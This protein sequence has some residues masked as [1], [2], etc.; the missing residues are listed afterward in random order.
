MCAMILGVS[1]RNA[2]GKGEVMAYLAERGFEG[3]SLSDVLRDELRRQGLAE[4]R[5]R[6]IALG[7]K[8]R[9][10]EGEAVLA[11]RTLEGCLPGRDYAIDS[12]RHPAEVEALAAGPQA[13]HLLWIEAGAEVR[14]ARLRQR[15]R[16][17]DP[18]TFDEFREL[19][20]RELQSAAKGGQQLLAVRDRSE[21]HLRNDGSVAE[22]RGEMEALLERL[23]RGGA[24]GDRGGDAAS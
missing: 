9:E 20:S 13:F 6:M 23:S 1:G 3:L 2:S 19:E 7:R 22:L 12:I 10:E 21:I 8:V 4:S 15:A 11:R 5:E 24:S 16:S 17:G 14:F 18:T